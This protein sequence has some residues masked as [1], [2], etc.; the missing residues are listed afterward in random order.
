MRYI[1]VQ[2]SMSNFLG[3]RYSRPFVVFLKKFVL[4]IHLK[5]SKEDNV[6]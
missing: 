2:N 5:A 3:G 1:A 4:L 6:D